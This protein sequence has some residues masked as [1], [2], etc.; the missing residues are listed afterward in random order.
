MACARSIAFWMMSTLSSSVGAM[1]TA[2]SVMISGSGWLGTSMMKQWLMR[3]AVRIPAVLETTAPINSSVCRLPFISASAA[4]QR[5]CST[6]LAAESWL[7]SDATI[8][9]LLM[10]RPHRAATSLM[11]SGGPTR[12]GAISP[13]L[14]P[15]T[16]LSRDTWSQG[17]A[18]AVLVGG[19]FRAVAMSRSYFACRVPLGSAIRSS[20]IT[21]GLPA[22]RGPGLASLGPCGVIVRPLRRWFG[23][24]G[25]SFR[26]CRGR[27]AGVAPGRKERLDLG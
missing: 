11:R 18:I 1:F 14:A 25:N 15:S 8:G 19:S 3:R 10:S 26:S 12:I 6:A 27:R 13:S 22:A 5:T 7:C 21:H 16:A 9:M 17:C 23:L 20:G 24:S 4:P 2:A